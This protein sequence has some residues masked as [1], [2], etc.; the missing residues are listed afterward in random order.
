MSFWSIFVYRKL[1][2]DLSEAITHIDC[3]AEDLMQVINLD[4]ERVQN[5]QAE[6]STNDSARNVSTSPTSLAD[7]THHSQVLNQLTVIQEENED[8]Y[9]FEY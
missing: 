1:Q 7:N 4:E 5:R 3:C 6:Q 2:N 8:D 9:S